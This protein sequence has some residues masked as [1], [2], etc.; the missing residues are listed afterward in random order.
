MTGQDRASATDEGL[1]TRIRTGT[2]VVDLVLLLSVPAILASAMALP[3]SLRASLAFEYAAPSIRTA[4]ASSFVHVDPGHFLVNLVGYA[5][6]VTP[7]YL[8]SVTSG[9]RRRF[10]VTFVS[11]V[12]ACPILLPYLNLAIVR[13]SLTVGF[14]GVL[15]ALY[16]YLPIALAGYGDE[17]LGLRDSRRTGPLCF[18][19]GLGLIAILT[20]ASVLANPVTVPVRGVTVPVRPVLAGTLATLLIALVLVVALY[21]VSIRGTRGLRSRIRAA[22]QRP[23]EGELAVVGAGVFLAVPFLTFPLDPVAGGGVVN[24]YSHF[25]GYALGFIATYATTAIEERLFGPS[26]PAARR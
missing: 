21:A 3:R 19:L 24:L 8:L 25:V 22:L 10:R 11:L 17:R 14:S 7:A 2:G 20:L 1:S 13:R 16:G 15:M 23:G 26:E 18:F 6:V 5:A 9:H 12:V 4:V